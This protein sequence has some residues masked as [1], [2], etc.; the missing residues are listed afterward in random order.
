MRRPDFRGEV[1]GISQ[2]IPVCPD[3]RASVHIQVRNAYAI[4]CNT[5][6]QC[7]NMAREGL[8]TLVVGRRI[9]S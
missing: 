4:I 7:G 3:F 8:R 2:S 9:L 1:L 6:L 5:L